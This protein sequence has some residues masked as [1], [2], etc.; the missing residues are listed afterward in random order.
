MAVERDENAR[1]AAEEGAA[2]S[3]AARDAAAAAAEA[4]REARLA[5]RC[6][7]C[8]PI[9]GARLPLSPGAWPGSRATCGDCGMTQ[10]ITATGVAARPEILAIYH[11][12]LGES[13]PPDMPT[14][15]PIVRDFDH[16]TSGNQTALDAEPHQRLDRAVDGL[17][18]TRQARRDDA[19]SRLRA[20]VADVQLAGIAAGARE[21]AISDA[22]ARDITALHAQKRR[23]IQRQRRPEEQARRRVRAAQRAEPQ[24]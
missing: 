20:L 16:A 21:R 2:Q 12:H 3:A 11:T 23:E 22:A 17:I 19:L 6:A 15:P 10:V 7:V 24:A 13:L 1:E 14:P 18:P 9:T 8:F 5:P 4:A